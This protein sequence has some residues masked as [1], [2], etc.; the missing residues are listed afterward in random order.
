M[1]LFFSNLQRKYREGLKEQHKWQSGEAT[2]TPT[3]VKAKEVTDLYSDVSI[4][5]AEYFMLILQKIYYSSFMIKK[6]SIKL[7]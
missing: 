5:P 7:F 4:N 3:A 6:T 1:I 2:N